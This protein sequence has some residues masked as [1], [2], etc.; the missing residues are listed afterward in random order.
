MNKIY[1]K[2]DSGFFKLF[3]LGIIIGIASIT[4]GLS[5]GVIA[6][7]L[8]LYT[9]A[10]DAIVN[11][12]RQFKKSLTFLF[13]LCLGA[14][15]G[16]ISFGIVM[17]PLLEHYEVA[18]I[19][20]FMGLVLG[21]LPSFFKEAASGGFRIIYIVP[22]L[23]AFCVGMLLSGTINSAKPEGEMSML[24]LL[25]SGGIFSVGM[26][27]PGISSSF[28]LLQM[29]VYDKLITAFLGFNIGVIFW[30]GIGFVIVSLLTIKLVHIALNKFHGQTYFAAFG[31]LVSSMVCVFPGFQTGAA[32]IVSLLL[33]ATGTAFAYI[34]MKKTVK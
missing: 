10:I 2:T 25:I 14:G 34:L 13:P 11:I 9:V 22:M 1:F 12:R 4:P 27:I 20:L 7:S 23:I 28:L 32:L 30:V 29:G 31:F 26:I 21:S 17:K 5:G 18:V 3:L 19:Y 8:G 33:F 24:T 6:V 15:I 16:I